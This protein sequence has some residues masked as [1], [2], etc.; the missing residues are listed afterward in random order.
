MSSKTKIVVL[1]M[2]EIIYT[3]IFAALAL[4]LILLLVFMFLPNKNESENSK[5]KY[6]PGVYTSDVT[7][8]NTALEVEVTVDESHINSIRFSNLDESV[9]AMYPLVQPAIEDIAEQIYDS[10]SWRYSYSSDS[11]YTSQLILG[12]IGDALKKASASE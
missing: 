1:H 6:I 8:N 11:P 5:Q 9:A 2:K 10:Q 3:V 12:A 4:L 7:L